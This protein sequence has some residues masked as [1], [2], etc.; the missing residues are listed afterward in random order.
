M[1]EQ[2]YFL[3]GKHSKKW[4]AEKLEMSYPT[5]FTKLKNPETFKKMEMDKLNQLFL[6]EN[7]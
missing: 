1:N 3:I 2:I 6:A 5:F 4:L 7:I